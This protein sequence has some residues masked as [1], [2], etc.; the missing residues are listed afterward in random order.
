MMGALV[1]CNKDENSG[2]VENTAQEQAQAISVM[3][4]VGTKG[5]VD[6][7]TFYEKATATMHTSTDVT[8]RTMIISAYR[9]PSAGQTAAAG[10]YFVGAE[11]ASNGLSGSDEKWVHTPAYYW[12]LASTL[13]FL[14]YSS[15]EAFASKDAKWAADNASSSVVLTFDRARC[16]DDVLFASQQM[17]SESATDKT[18]SPYATGQPVNMTFNHSQAW[19]EF[20]LSVATDEMKNKIAIKEIILENAYDKGTLTVTRSGASCTG[21]WTISNAE[22]ITF[23]DNYDVYGHSKTVDEYTTEQALIEQRE[24]ELAAAEASGNADAIAAA[25]TA[26]Q[27]AEDA[28][29]AAVAQYPVV[30]PLNAVG[31]VNDP[32]GTA[33]PG[34]EIR[35]DCSFLDMLLPE[36]PKANIIIRYVLAGRPDVLEYKY[37]LKQDGHNWEMGTKYIYDIDFVISE[38]TV[39]PSVSEWTATFDGTDLT[40]V[41]LL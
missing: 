3:S 2:V 20:Q 23:D 25:Q 27:A 39:A 9:T 31:G 35:T 40:P 1:S 15:T 16:Q 37:T 8:A 5:Y 32:S 10:N 19:I 13:D 7:T 29:A 38:I 21:A 24:A 30:N 22:N 6:G 11:F 26:L 28:L 33:T 14:A 4:G 17:T 18:A 12:P 34:A 41:E 36:Q